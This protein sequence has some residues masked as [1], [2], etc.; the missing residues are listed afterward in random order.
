MTSINYDVDLDKAMQSMPITVTVK[1]RGEN[2][3]KRR[4]NFT[5]WLL[6]RVAQITRMNL[7]VK[8][9]LEKFE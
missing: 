7:E 3:A 9:E 1:P 8:V 5:I 6:K 2:V 4:L